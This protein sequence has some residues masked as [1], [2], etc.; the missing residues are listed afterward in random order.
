MPDAI[1]CCNIFE[2]VEDR[3][4]FA[5]ICHDALRPGGYLVVS[6]PYSYPYHTD[7]IDTY[8]RPTPEEIAAMFPGYAL[9]EFGN[10]AE[11][12]FR[13][14]AGC[15]LGLSSKRAAPQVVLSV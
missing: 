2:H 4:R 8:L 12:D 5:S 10:R 13:A 15:Q 14:G 6:V 9:I 1:L 11:L 7:P 3:A